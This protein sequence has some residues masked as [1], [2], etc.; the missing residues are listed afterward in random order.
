MSTE[1]DSFEGCRWIP[2]AQS[3]F[4]IDVFDCSEFCQSMTS[5]TSDQDVVA[6]FVPLRSSI[7]EEYR[8]TLPPSPV[9][10]DCNLA[11]AFSGEPQ[12]G[13]LFKAELMEDKWDIYLYDRCLYFARSWTGQLNYVAAVNFKQGES[14]IR[15]VSV[16]SECNPDSQFTVGSVDYLIKSHIYQL[17]VPHPVPPQIPRDPKSV[18]M[19]SFSQFGR[20]ACFGTYEDT[21]KIVVPR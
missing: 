5:M 4:G 21:T 2:A 17:L 16:G 9:T 11:Y 18:T 19:F 6:R 13:A 12:D 20:R 1:P 7:G 8:G 10:I 14:R 15:S 3:K